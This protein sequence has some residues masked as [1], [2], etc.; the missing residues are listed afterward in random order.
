MYH[1]QSGNFEHR[2][3]MCN[4]L[5]AITSTDTVGSIEIKCTRCRAINTF[6]LTFRPGIAIIPS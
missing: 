5:L 3:D 2:C 1:K 4:K 6:H